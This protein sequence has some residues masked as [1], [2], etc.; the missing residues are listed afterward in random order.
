MLLFWFRAVERLG[1]GFKTD[2]FVKQ[3]SGARL[4]QNDAYVEMQRS[5]SPS[6]IHTCSVEA[7]TRRW[8]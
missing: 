8:I 3:K 6:L 4:L 7:S 2:D 5:V 1:A